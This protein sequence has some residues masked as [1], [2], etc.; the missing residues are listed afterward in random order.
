M[1]LNY[2]NIIINIALISS[3][4]AFFYFTYVP[5]V[6]R[7]VVKREVNDIMDSISKDVHDIVPKENLKV[8]KPVVVKN[9]KAPD[10]RSE[11]E[12]AKQKN[13]A[14]RSEA[15][16]YMGIFLATEEEKIHNK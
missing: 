12:K 10:M 2:A 14:I 8:Y 9:L 1:G 3:L 5:I 6:E 7:S 4:I 13:S 11:D 16:K 15:I